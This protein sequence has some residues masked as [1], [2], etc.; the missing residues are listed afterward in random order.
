M[1]EDH[2]E[3]LIDNEREWRRVIFQ[4]VEKLEKMTYMLWVKSGLWG[5]AGGAA[6]ALLAYLKNS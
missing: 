2:L 5:I 1:S 3:Q 6:V 4:K